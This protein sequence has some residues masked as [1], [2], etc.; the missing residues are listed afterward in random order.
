MPC[1][2]T[3]A[4]YRCQLA[5][6]LT[7]CTT[8]ADAH[9]NTAEVCALLPGM[10]HASVAVLLPHLGSEPY[11]LRSAVAT[12]LASVVGAACEED[13]RRRRLAENSSSSSSSSSSSVEETEEQEEARRE[14][15][16]L[17]R[18]EPQA[19]GKLK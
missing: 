4:Y 2:C 12:C 19:R 10:A 9:N 8:S 13:L 15:G 7:L 11:T 18:M 16:Q 17:V 5:K 3:D 6:S 14:G 1:C